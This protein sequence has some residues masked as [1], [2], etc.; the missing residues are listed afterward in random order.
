MQEGEEGSLRELK[1]KPVLFNVGPVKPNDVLYKKSFLISV[2]G[3]EGNASYYDATAQ[4]L[5]LLR[6]HR[7]K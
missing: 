2:I 7:L 1:H 4:E 5:S 3:K 6:S